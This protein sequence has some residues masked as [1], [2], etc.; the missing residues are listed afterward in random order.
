[1]KYENIISRIAQG[2][3]SR[4]DLR[5]LRINAVSKFQ[6]GDEEAREVLAAIDAGVPSDQYILFMGFCPDADI[7]NRLD[8]EWKQRGVCEFTYYESAVQLERFNRV[9][10]GDLVVLK[11]REKFGES[12]TLHGHGRVSRV[13][14]DD[15]G[16]HALVMDWSEQNRVI[17]VPLMGCNSTVDT[18]SIAAVEAEMPPEFFNWLE[19]LSN[20]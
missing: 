7:N 19:T 3:L 16:H 2:L 17:E 1:M 15:Q 11:K 8:I 10:A 20:A 9:C 5:D 12:M 6:A 4:S 14:I 13:E 18:K